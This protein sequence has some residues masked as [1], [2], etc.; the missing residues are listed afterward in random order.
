MDYYQ[1]GVQIR[2]IGNRVL[3]S[4]IYIDGAYW[5]GTTA[6]LR[7]TGIRILA[8]NP[9][10]NSNKNVISGNFMEGNYV[11]V[12]LEGNGNNVINNFFERPAS[13]SQAYAFVNG[14]NNTASGNVIIGNAV[15]QNYAPV[16]FNY[17]DYML[18]GQIGVGTTAPG[19]QM[20][21][22]KSGQ[23]LDLTSMVS[24]DNGYIA[25]N[26]NP[27]G[28]NWNSL[29]Q[30]G[31]KLLLYSGNG[32]ETGTLVIGPWSATAK[33]LRMNSKGFVGIGISSPDTTL[34]VNGAIALGSAGGPKIMSGAN[35]PT[36]TAANGSLYLRTGGTG[37]N[38]Y[39]RQ[40]GAWISK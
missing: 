6:S 30:A 7:S 2:G 35:A 28:G 27:L 9:N 40:N 24:G 10:F 33:G 12:S 23:S 13:W 17:T 38:L 19:A 25:V 8:A 1:Y 32:I 4:N 36:I 11:H 39:V 20:D 34:H 31:D 15:L 29:V 21:V 26:P 37:P 16:G 14:S 5:N 18:S 3:N 22:H